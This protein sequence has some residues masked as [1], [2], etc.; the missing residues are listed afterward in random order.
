MKVTLSWLREF[1]PDIEGDPVELSETLSALGLT[2]E[3]MTLIGDVVAGVVLAKVVDLRGHP[4]AD[5]I[6]LVD[7]DAGDGRPRQ[8]CCGAFNMA[9]RRPDPVRHAGNGHARRSR[10]RR[11]A[12]ARRAVVRH[13][14]VR[15]PSSASATT[16]RT[17]WC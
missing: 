17:S 4:S 12:D 7:V 13:V 3:E 16:R 11:E 8:V 9:G 15:G 10:D 14:P 5:R 1:A 2:V 6:Q